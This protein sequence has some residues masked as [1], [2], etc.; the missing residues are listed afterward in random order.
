MSKLRV[1]PEYEWNEDHQAVELIPG[2]FDYRSKWACCHCRKSF[3]RVRSVKVPE[4]VYC[5]DCKTKSTDMGHLFESP[6]KRDLKRWKIVE[7]L[8]R[9]NLRYNRVSNMVFLERFITGFGKFSP[10]EVEE[11]IIEYFER[12][13]LK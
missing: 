8:G 1:M 10:Q 9:N 11:N 2:S 7:I 4:D 5:P 13:N 6:P 3:T 12:R